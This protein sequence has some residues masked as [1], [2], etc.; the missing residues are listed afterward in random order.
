M[1]RFQIKEYMKNIRFNIAFVFIIFF[2]MCSSIILISNVD[3]QTKLYKVTNEYINK[4]NVF[5]D[6][7]DAMFIDSLNEKDMILVSQNVVGEFGPDKQATVT[8]YQKELIEKYPIKLDLGRNLNCKDNDIIEAVISYNPY[9]INVGDTIDFFVYGENE[10][11][12]KIKIVGVLSEGQRLFTELSGIKKDM[13]YEDFFPVYSYEQT[14]EARL[15]IS[16]FDKDK[17]PNVDDLS[18][19]RNGIVNPYSDE[20][21]QLIHEKLVKYEKENFGIVMTEV[22]PTGE[23]IYERSLIAYKNI[24]MKYIPLTLFIII[25]FTVCIIGIVMV[26]VSMDIKYYGILS[27]CG[28][29]K[30]KLVLGALVEMLINNLL[31]CIL[32]V[33]LCIVQNEFE[34]IGKINCNIERME[35]LLV[36]AIGIVITLITGL[37]TMGILKKNSI[38]K[39]M[40]EN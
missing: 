3:E 30:R 21:K 9:G 36:V 22:Y 25:L 20:E 16:E 27:L 14:G 5:I 40:K 19:F 12:V 8:V 1:I 15:F 28:M 11:K 24:V 26:K 7:S 18:I 10:T 39:I 23:E 17:I 31:A 2:M 13:I 38:I 35:E 34:I 33:N 37:E 32:A 6:F 4:N 29:S